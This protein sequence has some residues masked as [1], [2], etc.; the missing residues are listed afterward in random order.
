MFVGIDVAKDEL[1]VAVRPTGASWVSGNDEAGVRALVAQVQAL[2]PTLIILEATG[3][4]EILAVSALAAAA[5]PVIVVNP[6]QVRDFAKATG[7]LAKTD[8]IDAGVLA[9]F[10]ERV[11]PPVRCLPDD[12]TRE[13]E[14][15]VTRRRQLIDMLQAERT[16]VRPP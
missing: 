5:L 9:L 4:Y 10:G 12:A 15:I 3:G 16:L 2:T 1:V 6:R 14:A 7:Q 13:L 8:R 11:R